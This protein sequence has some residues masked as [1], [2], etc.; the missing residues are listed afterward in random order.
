MTRRK[1]IPILPEAA[2]AA[3]KAPAKTARAV[4][5]LRAAKAAVV[6]KARITAQKEE[7]EIP[8]ITRRITR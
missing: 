2:K 1:A 6:L 3:P 8:P 5:T 7:M 4:K